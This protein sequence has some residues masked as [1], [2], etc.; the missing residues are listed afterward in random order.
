MLGTSTIL[1]IV[2]SKKIAIAIPSPICLIGSKSVNAKAAVTT[3]IIEAA[4]VII[5]LVETKP[6]SVAKSLSPVSLYISWILEI[7]NTNVS[8]IYT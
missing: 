4:D 5:L 3:I 6:S 7:K 8:F 1:I 2:A